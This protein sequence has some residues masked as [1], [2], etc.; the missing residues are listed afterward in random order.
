MC[1]N[2][3]NSKS[4]WDEME[5]GWKPVFQPTQNSKKSINFPGK[6]LENPKLKSSGAET[7]AATELSRGCL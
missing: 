2:F 4:R 3:C 6:A 7:G 5:G 1:R